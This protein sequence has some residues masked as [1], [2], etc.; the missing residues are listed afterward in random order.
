M[1]FLCPCCGHE[2][3][4]LDPEYAVNS[5]RLRGDRKRM[6]DYLL[7]HFGK[8]V[9][10]ELLANYIFAPRVD[11]G[12]LITRERVTMMK[13]QMAPLFK[14]VGLVLEGAIA[15]GYRVSYFPKQPRV[16]YY[17]QKRPGTRSTFE[18]RA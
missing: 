5:L 14:S 6:A 12:P 2:T 15:T 16:D 4:K 7:W 18:V 13:C 8:F 1:A 3:G 9:H 11:G 10:Y 17:S